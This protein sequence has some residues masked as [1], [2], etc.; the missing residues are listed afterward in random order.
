MDELNWSPMTINLKVLYNGGGCVKPCGIPRAVSHPDATLT[1]T[2][3]KAFCDLV[4]A[5]PPTTID[6]AI[7]IVWRGNEPML[8]LRL[9]CEAYTLPKDEQKNRSYKPTRI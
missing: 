6:E 7:K 4:L 9:L 1:A 8:A 3:L 5:A 2:E